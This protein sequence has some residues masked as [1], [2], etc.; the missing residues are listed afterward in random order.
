MGQF[1]I[2]QKE[3]QSTGRSTGAAGSVIQIINPANPGPVSHSE[4]TDIKTVSNY[5]PSD[6]DLHL[7]ASDAD[8]LNLLLT[9]ILGI[10]KSDDTETV[11]GDTNVFSALRT[12]NE[13]AEKALSKIND[14]TLNGL[15]TLIKGFVSPGFT[16]GIIGDGFSLQPQKDA[17]GNF[18]STWKLIIDYLDVTKKATFVEIEIDKITHVGG[19]IM[20]SPASMKCNKVEAITG[21][22][23]C[24]FDN[25][26]KENTFVVGDQ[27]ICQVFS[28]PSTKRYWRYVMAVGL[29][30]IDLSETDCEAGSDIPEAGD[31]IVQLGN[32][33]NALRRGAL[34]LSSYGDAPSIAEYTDI[35]ILYD[36]ETSPYTL[37]NRQGTVIKPGDSEFTGKVTVKG[38]NGQKYR[39]PADRGAW[40]A[41]TYYYY[42]RVSRNGSLW[43]CIASPSTTLEPTDANSAAWLKQVEKGGNGLPGD[44]G[45]NAITLSLSNS[46]H[47][48]PT[49]TD[50]NNGNYAGAVCQAFVYDGLVDDSANWSL[51]IT[52]SA[53]VAGSISGKTYTITGLSE[54][55]GYVD[56]TVSKTGYPSIVKRMTIHKSKKGETGVT[57]TAY[58]LLTPPSIARNAAGV[59]I[60]ATFSVY[61]YSS[62]SNT[63]A[64]YSGKFT[65]SETEDGLNYFVKYTSSNN[66][67]G[68]TYT[69]TTASVKA[70]MIQLRKSVTDS[71]ILDEQIV[72]VVVDGAPGA[73]GSPGI[74]YMLSAN[75]NVI[76]KTVALSTVTYTPSTISFYPRKKVGGEIPVAPS[77][78]SIKIQGWSGTAWYD[79]VSSASATQLTYSQAVSATYS[80]YRA[81]LTL[82][83][84]LVQ[85]LVINVVEDAKSGKDA[86]AY[87]VGGYSSYEAYVADATQ[88]GK[89]L[90]AG[91]YLK[92]EIID[93]VSLFA[94]ALQISVIADLVGTQ[95]DEKLVT[96]MTAF[97]MVF[98]ALINGVDTSLNIT[99]QSL[100]DLAS[101]LAGA[102][103]SGTNSLTAFV[104]EQ[105]VPSGPTYGDK[106]KISP[107]YQ[108][109]PV[110]VGTIKWNSIGLSGTFTVPSGGSGDLNRKGGLWASLSAHFYN[111]S[112]YLGR[113]FMG[114]VGGMSDTRTYTLSGT[115]P[116]GSCAVPVNA[117]RVFLSAQLWCSV[118]YNSQ[119][120]PTCTLNF[121]A[122]AAA[123]YFSNAT[124]VYKSTIS[125]DGY[126]LARDSSNYVHFKATSSEV[127]FSFKGRVNPGS[128]ISGQLLFLNMGPRSSGDTNGV[129]SASGRLSSSYSITAS[130]TNAAI[131][132]THNYGSTN[133]HIS[134]APQQ[135]YPCFYTVSAKTANAFTLTVYGF[136]GGT[137]SANL[138]PSLTILMESV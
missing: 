6:K 63:P 40:I 42:D 105:W 43:L 77:D 87:L 55:T 78:C 60:P 120:A 8:K 97:G 122:L 95:F 11:A 54:D 14:D 136:Y 38:G 94:K 57:P 125:P 65:I 61:G 112:T 66:E 67:A 103:V 52:K 39:V 79:L 22:Y 3:K 126:A 17:E 10:I 81:Q 109:I 53:S 26:E 82:G 119:I 107:T 48:I 113:Q 1:N 32:R 62:A 76:T 93:T 9:T 24:F 74:S 75:A 36:G 27:A 45:A 127:L 106:I 5:S 33:N 19:T 83:A 104:N 84:V 130:S 13:I 72:P 137:W 121:T 108:T 23:R 138:N 86:L 64:L 21:G 50:G 128:H 20:L 134:W 114:T 56:F 69:P 51:V 59:Y 118:E 28:L 12:L 123:A 135:T 7:T 133:Y 73:Q 16:G 25:S 91:G 80:M 131:T 29:D 2:I 70:F 41:G 90:M 99:P 4:L 15:I 35:G 85:E 98:P 68:K 117:N 49:D 115:I 31:D 92:N 111:G 47:A 89:T 102:S 96:V 71:T 34:I 30:Y 18:L 46:E 101:F 116:A 88:F 37:L 100:P 129:Y 58:W 44:D 132:V 110:G 124:G